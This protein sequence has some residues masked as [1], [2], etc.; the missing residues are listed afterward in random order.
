MNSITIE[1]V[2]KVLTML[3]EKGIEFNVNFLDGWFS[4]KP[5]EVIK[6]LQDPDKLAAAKYGVTVEHFRAWRDFEKD[7][8]CYALT[9]KRQPCKNQVQRGF[10][11]NQFIPGISEYCVVHQ[12]HTR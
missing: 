4:L 9:K 3:S 10:G 1:Q 7:P 11:V 5:D 2:N 8:H 6:Y 12:Q